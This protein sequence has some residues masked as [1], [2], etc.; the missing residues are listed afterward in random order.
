MKVY[1]AGPMTGRQYYNLHAFERAQREWR[2]RGHDAVTPF[3]CNN[4]VWRDAYGRDFDP[5][6]D[7]CDWG[8][9]LLNEMVIAD[10][11]ALCRADAIVLLPEWR[12][13]KGATMEVI[14]AKN[15]GKRIFLEDGTELDV[16]AT[17][18]FDADEVVG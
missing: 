1:I 13:S 6:S 14:I 4:V 11:Q 17:I 16:R 8:D 15:L 12:Q 2:L 9:P 7:R 5:T 10:V 3:E 18:H